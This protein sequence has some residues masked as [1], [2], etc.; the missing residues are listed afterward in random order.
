MFPFAPGCRSIPPGPSPVLSGM[1]LWLESDYGVALSGSNVLTI[2]DRSGHVA[3]WASTAGY[4]PTAAATGKGGKQVLHFDGDLS[5]FLQGDL[6]WDASTPPIAAEIFL[7]FKGNIAS[8]VGDNTGPLETQNTGYVSSWTYYGHA[9]QV[10]MSDGGRYN[11]TQAH[12][13]YWHLLDA[14]GDLTTGNLAVRMWVDTVLQYTDNAAGVTMVWK[15][16]GSPCYIAKNNGYYSYMDFSGMLAYPRRLTDPER[17]Q[18]A[19]Y[20]ATRWI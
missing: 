9:M 6:G 8:G 10:L 15:P 14:M 19:A 20:F 5:Q 2:A 7:C 18:N 3:P 13:E 11:W 17:A 1:T 12:P 16:H 4:R